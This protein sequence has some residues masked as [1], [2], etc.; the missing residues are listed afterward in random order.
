LTVTDND[1][2]INTST[3]TAT[4][5]DTEPTA[6]LSA[7]PT[8]GQE[9]LTVN[10]TDN[11]TSHDGIVAW[12]W[13]F[14]NDNVTDSTEQNSTYVYAEE[15]LYTV[16][17]T[18]NESDEDSDTMIKVDYI[19]VGS[20]QPG[21]V[22]L[23]DTNAIYDWK[24]PF[25]DAVANKDEWTQVPYGVTDSYTWV[26]DPMIENEHYYLFLCSDTHDSVD[27]HVKIDGGF[28][29]KNEIYKVYD[30]GTRDFGM[31][32]IWTNI[33]KNTPGE[34]IVESAGAGHQAGQPI[35]T[36]YHISREPWMEVKPIDRVN[37][38]GMHDK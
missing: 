26:G 16:S 32:A 9:P 36:T 38:Q 1:D 8:S 34:V 25:Y 28:G 19:T 31:G 3:T 37:Q 20:P 13:D 35:V 5:A 22:I 23:W 14:N 7:T 15:G 12:N 17:L 29:A 27:L 6:D 30:A 33:L 24:S 18:V 21:D 2:E 11:S 4:I 10:F